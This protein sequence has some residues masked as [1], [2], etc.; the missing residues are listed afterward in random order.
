MRSDPLKRHSFGKSTIS[1]PYRLPR[2]TGF[3]DS[4]DTDY[5]E[6]LMAL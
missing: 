2:S 4:G 1:E 3:L 6:S 5:M